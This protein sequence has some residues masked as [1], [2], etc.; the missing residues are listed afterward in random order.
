M[1][2]TQ[3]SDRDDGHTRNL[4]RWVIIG[5][6]IAVGAIILAALGV[7]YVFFYDLD[8]PPAPALDDALKV[9]LPTATPGQ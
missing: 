6:V 1:A 7:W 9:L 5:A 2:G 4:R 3:G 8:V